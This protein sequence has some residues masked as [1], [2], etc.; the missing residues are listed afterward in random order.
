MVNAW[1]LCSVPGVSGQL[2]AADGCLLT[3]LTGEQLL[4][5]PCN[6]AHDRLDITFRSKAVAAGH[7]QAYIDW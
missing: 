1:I 2:P 5:P 6:N 4:L 3:Y 7:G